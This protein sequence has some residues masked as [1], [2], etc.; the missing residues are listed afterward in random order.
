MTTS[1]EAGNPKIRGRG[2]KGERR[3][4][5][6]Q[7]E[8]PRL[9]PDL[10]LKDWACWWRRIEGEAECSRRQK[11]KERQAEKESFFRN[12]V[13][14]K[15][16]LTGW[17]TWWSRMEA[18]KIKEEKFAMRNAEWSKSRTYA[19]NK[20]KESFIRKFFHTPRS[21]SR[22]SKP[23]NQME[24]CTAEVNIRCGQSPKRKINFDTISQGSPAKIR[25]TKTFSQN[26]NYWKNIENT[27]VVPTDSALRTKTKTVN[28]SHT[29]LIR[30]EVV[31]RLGSPGK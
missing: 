19:N 22:P 2:M 16:I 10:L 28:I 7:A 3:I 11:R 25:K 15:I 1:P 18:E 6:P 8:N 12:R 5:F 4:I 14:P 23:R 24:K 30:S 26:L 17:T 13:Q 29:R 9:D 21:T 31:K 27:Q 20:K